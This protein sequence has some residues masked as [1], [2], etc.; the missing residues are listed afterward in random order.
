MKEPQETKMTN[1]ER[2]M[3][4]FWEKVNQKCKDDIANITMDVIH[5][6]A[7][8]SETMDRIARRC[9]ITYRL[10]KQ[11]NPHCGGDV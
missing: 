1:E 7:T 4:R 3:D 9:E 11:D 5:G 2:L 8:A 6:R 10:A